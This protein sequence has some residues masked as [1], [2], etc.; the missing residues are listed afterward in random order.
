MISVAPS[1]EK[2]GD[3]DAWAVRRRGAAESFPDLVERQE[4]VPIVL[5]QTDVPDVVMAEVEDHGVGPRTDDH[6]HPAVAQDAAF[7]EV[8]GGLVHLD[9]VESGA[10]LR[11]EPLARRLAERLC[12]VPR[13][14]ATGAHPSI[15]RSSLCPVDASD[16]HG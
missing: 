16:W 14:F 12:A 10:L 1:G 7:E 8:R 4:L 5:G 11:I 6:S 13:W 2:P 15:R 3:V 9:R